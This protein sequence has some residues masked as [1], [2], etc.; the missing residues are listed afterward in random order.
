MY[1]LTN[2]IFSPVLLS[3]MDGA[4]SGSNGTSGIY[5]T[6]VK[7]IENAVLPAAIFILVVLLLVLISKAAI[8]WK[9]GNRIILRPIV[10]VIICIIILSIMNFSNLVSRVLGTYQASSPKQTTTQSQQNERQ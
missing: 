7:V 6:V 3:I 1:N 10:I 8:D 2:N 5:G 9:E 4:W